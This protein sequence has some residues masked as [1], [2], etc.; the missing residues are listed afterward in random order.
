[1]KEL[2]KKA[3]KVVEFEKINYSAYHED[4][5][6]YSDVGCYY[7][8]VYNPNY[9]QISSVDQSDVILF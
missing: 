9:S 4:N 5:S 8:F 7:A 2:K 6:G 3:K 1:M